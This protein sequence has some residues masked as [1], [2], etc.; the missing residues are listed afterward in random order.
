MSRLYGVPTSP[1]THL[2]VRFG[3]AMI[4]TTVTRDAAAADAWV[5]SVRASSL[6]GD[7]LIGF[8]REVLGLT[9]EKPYNVTMSNWEKHDLDVAQIQY[10]CIDAYV[11]YKLGEKALPN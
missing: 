1:T 10:A 9:M 6:L 2:T 4:D 8:A 5:R 3:S 11:S 7:D